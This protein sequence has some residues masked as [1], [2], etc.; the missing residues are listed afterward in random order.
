M[1]CRLQAR[2]LGEGRK[3]SQERLLGVVCMLDADPTMSD[4]WN[5]TLELSN[6]ALPDTQSLQASS[7]GGIP[8]PHLECGSPNYHERK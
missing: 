6:S 4:S 7:T 3:I 8:R 2:P 5:L 1:S